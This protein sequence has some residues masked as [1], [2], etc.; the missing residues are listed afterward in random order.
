MSTQW[1]IDAHQETF[2]TISRIALLG[3]CA[4]FLSTI[5]FLIPKPLPFMRIGLANL[6][7]MI[8]LGIMSPAQYLLLVLLKIVGQGLV[9]GTLFSY[10]F[11]FSAGGSL[12][13]A[14]IMFFLFRIG[15]RNISYIGISA[16]GAFTSNITQL[17][18]ARYLVFGSGIWLVAPPFLFMGLISSIIL[19]GFANAFTHR[20]VWYARERGG[21]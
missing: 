3:A 5:E 17:V 15:R 1:S 18:M 21:S 9:N 12:T 11:L 16:A 13:S 7:L 19:G 8:G 4:L 14:C 10:I 2:K 20:S 6:P